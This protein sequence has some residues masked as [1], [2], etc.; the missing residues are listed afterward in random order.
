[1]N[2]VMKKKSSKKTVRKPAAS[3]Q[4]DLIDCLDALND[5]CTNIVTLGGLLDASGRYPACETL[6]DDLVGN[7][8]NLIVREA[9]RMREWLEM[10]RRGEIKP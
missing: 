6:R 3:R 1:M 9:Q 7:A 2:P 4:A 5:H 10:L 8:G